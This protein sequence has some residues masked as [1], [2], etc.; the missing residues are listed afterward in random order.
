[1]KKATVGMKRIYEGDLVRDV[2]S[3]SPYLIPGEERFIEAENAQISGIIPN[4]NSGNMARDGGHLILSEEEA[5]DLRRHWP[6]SERFIRPLIG[7]KEI[8]QGSH[9]YCLWIGDADADTAGEDFLAAVETWE[10]STPK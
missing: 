10:N 5:S 2:A 6:S 4:M 1:V 9:R 7:T 3:I 8:N